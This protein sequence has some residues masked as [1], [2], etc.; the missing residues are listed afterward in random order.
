MGLHKFV[1]GGQVPVRF[2]VLSP[3]TPF[4]FHS[5]LPGDGRGHGGNHALLQRPAQVCVWRKTTGSQH[6]RPSLLLCAAL[7]FI[8]THQVTDAGMEAIARSC[9]GLN[10][11]VADNYRFGGKGIASSLFLL[12]PIPFFH[13]DNPSPSSCGICIPNPL[14]PHHQVTD[15]GMEAIARSCT[16]LNKFVAD[17]YR[18]G[19]KGIAALLLHCT[20]LNDLTLV[21]SASA[22]QPLPMPAPSKQPPLLPASLPTTLALCRLCLKDQ[23]NAAMW[24]PVMEACGGSLETLILGRN[25]GSWDVALEGLVAR[26]KTAV[27]R[28]VRGVERVR[29]ETG[30][31]RGVEERGGVWG[32][33]GDAH[34][35][36]QHG[37]LGRAHLVFNSPLPRHSP[38]QLLVEKTLLSDRPL[39]GLAHCPHLELIGVVHS[40]HCTQWSLNSPYSPLS[41]CRPPFR[42]SWKGNL[43]GPRP[44]RPGPL[45]VEKTLLSDHALH[46]LAQCPNLELMGI[47]HSPHCTDEG[48]AAVA[49]G[50][51]QLRWVHIDGWAT[52]HIGDT[53]L[54]AIAKHCSQ[55]QLRWVHI[56][57]WATGH[58]GDVALTAIAKH[59]SQL[60]ML[61]GHNDGRATV[62]SGEIALT[63]IAK[64]CSKLQVL[65]LP[66]CR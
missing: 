66:V 4:L 14:L 54:T 32:Q 35:G 6:H 47:V 40:T 53:A 15:A 16:G 24:Q 52:G 58:I 46:A 49:A 61:W 28:Q 62:H 36:A 42:C 30:F 38:L 5:S 8:P 3:V 63:A 39:H 17:N 43:I 2:G 44:T 21:N 10:K 12:S 45:L 34:S 31:G 22:G 50:C 9:A 59:C 65:M 41:P 25:M 29:N 64:H 20:E 57:G 26:S 48:M 11:F 55:L 1:C 37:Q 27:L 33:P 23:R 51:P 60:Q 56:D 7:P 18:F 19:G 13:Q